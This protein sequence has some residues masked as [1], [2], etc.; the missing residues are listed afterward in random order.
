LQYLYGFGPR[1]SHYFIHKGTKSAVD[2]LIVAA[3]AFAEKLHNEIWV[4]DNSWWEKDAG[5]YAEVQRANWKDVILK[6][7]F[8]D[9][10]RND[11]EGFYTQEKIYK[12]CPLSPIITSV[13]SF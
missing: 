6:Q 3:G 4:Y 2:E 9:T 5:L 7:E 13:R 11:I 8:K 12:V 10:I 1:R